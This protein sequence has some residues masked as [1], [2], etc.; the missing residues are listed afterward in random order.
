MQVRMEVPV[1]P[2]SLVRHF[3]LPVEGIFGRVEIADIGALGGVLKVQQI[4]CLVV[5]E[6]L[7]LMLLLRD[8]EM[9]VTAGLQPVLDGR[10]CHTDIHLVALVGGSA[11]VVVQSTTFHLVLVFEVVSRSTDLRACEP[12]QFG[13]AILSSVVPGL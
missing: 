11:V 5:P 10:G 1:F 9:L 7:T 4:L 6:G 8:E 3:V 13:F 2:F 12:R